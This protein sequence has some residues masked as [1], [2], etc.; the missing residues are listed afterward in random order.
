M[1]GQKNYFGKKDVRPSLPGVKS[2]VDPAD[3]TLAENRKTAKDSLKNRENSAANDHDFSAP[4]TAKSGEN[5]ALDRPLYTGR[6]RKP[7][8]KKKKSR[9]RR[10]APSLL[11]LAIVAAGF[12]GLS[13]LSSLL[14]PHIQTLFTQATDTQY[15]AMTIREGVLYKEI[16]SGQTPLTSRMQSRFAKYNIDASDQTNWKFNGKTITADNFDE[17][18]HSDTAFREAY[19]DANQGRA[20]NFFDDTA[21]KV[22]NKLGLSRDVFNGYDST[23]NADTDESNY[24]RIMTDYFNGDANT[25]INTAEDRPIL[26]DEGNETGEYERVATGENVSTSERVATSNNAVSPEAM[27]KARNYLNAAGSK[28]AA[29]E[30]AC[31]VLQVGNMIAVAVASNITYSSIH[32]TM[33]RNETISR[34]MKGDGEKS[35]I[36]FLLNW[37]TKTET[38]TIT[39]PTTGEEV[40]LTGSPLEAEGN[41]E[42][43]GGL[44]P[45]QN[46]L[47]YYSVERSFLSV[48]AAMA[49][50]ALTIRTCSAARAAGASIS[51]T[52]H[53]IPGAG[54]L[55]TTI[56][57]LLEVPLRLGTQIAVGAALGILVPTIARVLF[58]NPFQT[59]IGIPG[60]E[61]YARGAAIANA[62]LAQTSIGQMPSSESKILEYNQKASVALAEEAEIDRSHRS[63]FDASS[64]NTFLG[65]I[66][67]STFPLLASLNSGFSALSTFTG[68]TE[69]SIASLSS[70][71]AAGENSSYLTTFT[72]NCQLGEEL[73][74]RSNMYC[75]TTGVSDSSTL[76]IPTNDET[77]QSVL[78]ESIIVHENGQEEILDN[79]PFAE[80]VLYGMNR[81]S[82]FGVRDANIANACE[83]RL[84]IYGSSIPILEDIVDIVSALRTEY[85]MPIADGSK[86]INSDDNPYWEKEK[87]HSL[88]AT[89][90]RIKDQMGYY[91]QLGLENPITAYEEK[92]YAAHP[93]D[94]SRSG[95]LARI[96][97]LSKEDTETVLY[98]ADYTKELENY[99]SSV[100][101]NFAGANSEIFS[102]RTFYPTNEEIYISDA[103]QS[104][105]FVASADATKYSYSEP[106]VRREE[107][108]A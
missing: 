92:Y 5:P 80:F 41:R 104:I 28:V 3:K 85:C 61:A 88:K 71:Y 67:S 94:N 32:D 17:I 36:N 87:Y 64:P 24:N 20:R 73:G 53:A 21:E 43:L 69:N 84:G 29:T 4:K 100:A 31:A 9:L 81:E 22:Y 47:R 13:S 38:T 7:R 16:L 70:T 26:D 79:S 19:S 54:L 98:I 68:I 46:K 107:T 35:G 93:L 6:G 62:K 95:Y 15:A 76:Y 74:A 51:L 57:L 83:N 75:Y 101:Y 90:I 11:I 55:R 42:V 10:A 27:E 105:T 58:T 65:S 60:G 77:Y 82:P 56:G 78:S 34:A 52:A 63:P 59:N 1:A 45:D 14:G 12:I 44:T 50:S 2:P 40:T 30:A 108:T 23:G 99:D 37:F 72:D 18:Y 103:S 86:Y 8:E 49:T 96:S 91:T 97:G 39:D 25:N 33:L 48:I 66:V 102:A 106:V 89:D